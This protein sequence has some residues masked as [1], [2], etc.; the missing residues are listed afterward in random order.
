MRRLVGCLVVLACAAFVSCGDSGAPTD[1][2][3]MDARRIL[4]REAAGTVDG[5]RLGARPQTVIDRLGPP[6]ASPDSERMLPARAPA[7][8]TLGPA[9]DDHEPKAPGA[10]VLRYADTLYLICAQRTSCSGRVS[11]VIV[12]G[13]GAITSRGVRI[14]DSLDRANDKYRLYCRSKEGGDEGRTVG[15]YCASELTN[16]RFI[17]FIGDPIDRIDIMLDPT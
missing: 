4:I 13:A 17:M 1:A 8:T 12:T 6:P 5:V 2:E 10:P 3:R 16:G 14:G 7:D 15:P 11:K 9:S